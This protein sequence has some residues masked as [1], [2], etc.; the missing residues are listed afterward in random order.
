MRNLIRT[1]AA[2]VMRTIRFVMAVL[3]ALFG[4]IRWS[5]P[6]WMRRAGGGTRRFARR[7]STRLDASRRRNPA[8]FWISSAILL[9]LV[10]SG[11]FGF[12]WYWNRPQPNYVQIKGTLPHATELK[13]DAI[14]EPLLL[15]FS[16]SAARLGSVGKVVTSGITVDPP[17]EGVWKWNTDSELS[18][19]PHGDWEVGRNY[20]VTFSRDFFA[21]QV[22]LKSHSYKFRSPAFEVSNSDAAFY[23]D[24]TDPKNK[25]A[26]TTIE[27]THPVDKADLEKHLA[28]RMRVDPV[29]DFES[30]DTLPFGFKV[31]YDKTGSIAYIHSD[32]FPIPAKEAAMQI[33]ML[34]DVHSSRGGPGTTKALVQTVPIPGITTYFQIQGVTA[35]AIANDRDEMERVAIL[36]SSVPVRQEDLARSISVV[37]LPKDRPAIGDQKL[38]KDFAWSDPTEAVPEV[39]T[40]ATPVVI[41]WMPSEQDFSRDQSFKF[42][43]DRGRYLLVTVHH[44]LVGFGDYKLSKNFSTVIAVPELPNLL[45]IASSGSVLSLSGEKKISIVSRGIDSMQIEVSRLLPGSVSHLVSQTQGSFSQPK[46]FNSEFGLDDLSQIFTEIRPLTITQAD[47]PQYSVFDFGPLQASGA[48]PRGLFQIEVHA[49]DPIKN[50]RVADG[51]SDHRII[52]LTD[53]G[54]LVKDSV[55]GNHEAFIQ[56]IESGKPLPGIDV[57][58]LGRNGLPIVSNKTD[59]NGHVSFPNLK[60]FKRE[61]NPTVYVVEKDNDFSFLPYDRADR[62]LDLSRFDTGGLYTVESEESLQAYLFSDRGIYRPGDQINIGLVVKREDW[63]P[64]ADGLPLELVVDDPRGFE[65]RHQMIKFGPAGFEAYSTSTA[66]DSPTGTYQFSLFIVRDNKR[67]ALLGS[68]SVRVEDFQPDRMTI[69]A[70]LSTTAKDGWI[71]PDGLTGEVLLRNLFGT[72]AVGRRVKGSFKLAPWAVSFPKFPDYRFVDPYQTKKSYDEDL[73]E[74][75]TDS[76]GR[77]KFD[78]RMDRFEKGVYRLRFIAEG[79]EPEGGRSVIGDATATVSPAPFLVAFK[80]DGDLNYIDKDVDREVSLIAVDFQLKQIEVPDLSTE[81][82]EYRYVSVL[83]KQKNGTLAYQSVRKEISR[84]KTPITIPAAGLKLKLA[85]ANPG[86][87]ALVIRN[88]KGEE[89][90]RISFEVMGHANVSRSL[91]REAEL[92]IKLDKPEYAPG[93]EAEIEIQ[94]PYVG[95]GLITVERDKV[96]NS[97]WFSTTTTESVQKIKI[98]AELEGN[99]YITV[100]FVRSLDSPEVF[101]SPLSYGS[102]AFNI[103]RSRHTEGVTIDALPMVRPGDPLTINYKTDGPAKLVVVVVDEGILQV[104]RYHTPDPLSYFFRK[105]ALEVTT[106]QILDQILPELHLLNQASAPGGDEEALR[107]HANN[108]FKRKGQKPV[109]FWSGII[110]SD[111]KPGSVNL[112]VPDY[113]NG[114]LRVFAVAATDEA[115]G[116]TEKK[117]VSQGY[118]VIQPQAPYFATPGDEFDITALVANN[119]PPS[120][121]ATN[122]VTVDLTASKELQILG[123][124]SQKVSIA[125]GADSTVR[126]R[127]RA[128]AVPGVATMTVTSSSGDKR[129]AYTLDMSVR[130]A[131]PFVTTVTSG[132]VKKGLLQSVKADLPVTRALY[133]EERDVEGSASAIPLGLSEGMIR[134]LTKYPY[135][136]TEQIVSEAF[137]AVVLGTRPELGIS[138]EAST[139]SLNLALTTLQG[140]QNADGAFGLWSA[141]PEVD[142][143]VTAYATNFLM[144]MRDHG[145]DVPPALLKQALD[146]LQTNVATAGSTMRELR[147]QSYALYLLARSGVVVTNQLGSVREVL[148][149]DFADSWHDDTTALYLAATYQ[150][151]KMD[152]QASELLK[153]APT[154]HPIE[155]EYDAYYND[156]VYRS[157]YV[158]LLAKHFPD[159]AKKI[160]G[161]QILKIADSIT[162][163]QIDTLSAA[164]AIVALDAYA[165]IAGVPTKSKL[166]FSEILADKSTRTLAATGDLFPHASVS[167]DAK[168]VHVEGETPFALFYQLTQA[169]YDLQPP[170][171]EISDKIEVFREY[172]NEKH[173]VITTIQ[174]DGKVD[175]YVSVRAIDT[176]VSNV[177][178]T[179]LIPGGFEAD[180]SPEGLGSRKSLVQNNGTWSPDYIDVREDRLIFFGPIGTD[181]QTF[182]YRLKP[183]NRGKFAVPP[184]YAEGMYDRSIQARSLGSTFTI[185]DAQPSTPSH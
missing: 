168:S 31:T 83:T 76:D 120:G 177:A 182:V 113:F 144:E 142:N 95:A 50:E 150:L 100:T 133:P 64:I 137:P 48:L 171:K 51:P 170:T 181:A 107:A 122:A 179:D 86:S 167:P 49:W 45:K 110:D 87:F 184:L 140:R 96:Y 118:F 2:A 136:C 155:P 34:A 8:R 85:T 67:K 126:F 127:A 58:V 27:F 106:W 180:I 132:Y 1:V 70:T 169:G 173:E 97:M 32:S 84:G 24:P 93:E 46:F 101:T 20:T 185:E 5:P 53:L 166:S 79:F 129:A 138:A 40:E 128:N 11:A 161:D 65:V 116:V 183:T 78:L 15:D 88:D 176:P 62:Q 115:I 54:V 108:P 63:K 91:E 35:Q 37:M 145:L 151:L 71:S 114:T 178:I 14:V 56:S 26:V 74:T 59:A 99:G 143:F 33:K 66:E 72:A 12:R 7:I 82:I 23:E 10:A 164:D 112:P 42:T 124:H 146:S 68:T 61:K 17:L 98:P 121:S 172:R 165:K 139:K 55:D 131:S 104:A 47:S 154:A 4:E 156:L 90:N 94:A 57:E 36:S 135:G 119:L 19:Q 38:E 25:Q 109:A 21:T 89:L 77:A 147:A 41:Q 130:P 162:T 43:A 141:G 152:Q 103:S 125:P 13:P 134:Y 9:L 149:R 159:R 160:S 81:L 175:V 153:N 39:M 92:K 117:V 16:S 29:K 52:L 44:G 30:K 158:Y 123:D 28:L 6:F 163:D 75:T 157:T 18:L 3:S 60:D 80:P 102:A 148:D 73:G 105:R 174:L 111:G 22:L 69:K